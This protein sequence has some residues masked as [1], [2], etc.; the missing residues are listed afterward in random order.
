MDNESRILILGLARE[1]ESLARYFA[2]QGKDVTITDIASD[3]RLRS[4]VDSLSGLRIQ[5]ALGVHRP[6]LVNDA[7]VLYVSPG[8]PETSPVYRAAVERGV[9]IRSMT[10]LFFDLCPGPIVGVTGSSG[11]TTTTGLIGDILRAAHRDVVV[12]GNIGRSMLDLLPSIGPET[13]VVLELS[14]FQLQLLKRSPHIAV[15]TN[16]S[17]NHLDRHGTMD[18]YIAAKRAIVAHQAENDWA[19]LNA[20]DADVAAFARSTPGTVRWFGDES[21]PGAAVRGDSVGLT[22]ESD[23]SPVMPVSEIPLLGRHNIE[24]V[25]A[26]IEAA[27]ILEV[28]PETMREAVAAFR[29]APH[30]LQTVTDRGGVTFIDDSIATSPARACVAIRAIDA[31]I[32]LIAGGR[33]KRLP[34]DEFAHL[35]VR[36]VRLL[37]LIGEAADDIER[38]VEQ[39]GEDGDALEAIIRCRTLDGAVS[40]AARAARPG[41]AVLLSP[42][43]T[44]FDMFSDYEE[45]GAAFARAVERL[46][47]A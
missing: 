32:L 37:F 7:D 26:A 3:E 2:G 14:S 47:A 33:D 15:V 28:E 10:T 12:G 41:E 6:D 46:H 19:V 24:N 5:T 29:P 42:A 23:F 22:A 18:S 21:A 43:C 40:R 34:W 35:V 45:R 38:A 16:I 25:L 27:A 44:S 20:G 39:V 36:R 17:P 31:P 30:R 13:L 11:K 8:V 4:K 1:G 9:P